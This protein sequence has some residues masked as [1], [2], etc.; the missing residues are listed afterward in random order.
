[1]RQRDRQTNG[2][3]SQAPFPMPVLAAPP[4]AEPV[5]EA[6]A[7]DPVPVAPPWIEVVG[8]RI[9][10]TK[11]EIWLQ[12]S[13]VVRDS[14]GNPTQPR[15]LAPER[16]YVIGNLLV[17]EEMGLWFPLASIHYGRKI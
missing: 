2:V 3:T 4:A 7:A 10:L 5:T 8:D 17:I 9:N 11:P 12:G 16:A 15:Q 1:M 14:K 6:P 13:I